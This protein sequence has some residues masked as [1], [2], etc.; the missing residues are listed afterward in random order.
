VAEAIRHLADRYGAHPNWL[1]HEGKP[2]IIFADVYRVPIAGGQTPLQAWAAIRAQADPQGK[3]V[4]IAEGLDASYL[5]VFDGLY[6][7]KV[8]HAAY[9]DDYVKASRWAGNVRA[10]Q[11]RTGK[12]KLWIGT[13][14]PGWD[15]LRSGCQADVRIPSTPHRRDREGGAF[16]RATFEAALASNPDWLWVNSF[17]EWVEGSYIEPSQQ[18]GDTYLGL[19]RELARR[20]KS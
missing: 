17:N 18:Y 4:W 3:M 14:M 10:W 13:V 15:D 5:E 6:V 8:T 11:E 19:T 2:V 12:Q 1:T 9:P 20:F 16:Y 7:Y